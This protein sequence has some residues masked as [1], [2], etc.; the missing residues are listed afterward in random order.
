MSS[1][2]V[3]Q[4]LEK[5]TW[6]FGQN[7]KLEKAGLYSLNLRISLWVGTQRGW[8]W[9]DR[10]WLFSRMWARQLNTNEAWVIT[11]SKHFVSWGGTLR[12]C[13]KS[14]EKCML[15]PRVPATLLAFP[16][17][18]PSV[19]TSL[20]RSFYVKIFKFSSKQSERNASQ[21]AQLSRELSVQ[22]VLVIPEFYLT[23]RH[24][25]REA[26]IWKRKVTIREPLV[27]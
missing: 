3:S 15:L 27:N 19:W 26:A 16:E 23:G 13:G 8:G 17:W 14:G 6:Q 21:Q 12:H 4:I 11:P 9:G 10:G 25:S 24:N 7:W 20:R 2:G 22:F 18:K 5:P 1:T